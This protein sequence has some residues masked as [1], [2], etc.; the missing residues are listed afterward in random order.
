MK[1]LIRCPICG[2]RGLDVV[3]KFYCSNSTC[4]NYKEGAMRDTYY[5]IKDED[6]DDSS[7]YNWP[8]YDD[9]N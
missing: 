3:F 1:K 9:D 6:D 5:S 8:I 7:L 2:E 4:Q